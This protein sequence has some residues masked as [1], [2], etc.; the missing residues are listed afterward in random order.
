M[1]QAWLSAFRLRTLP[2]A[3]SSIGMGSFLAAF[4]G[5]FQWSIFALC[6]STTI[7][8]QILSNLANDYGDSIHGADSQERQGPKRMVQSGEISIKAMRNAILVFSLL[9][10]FSGFY[11][12]YLAIDSWQTFWIFLGLGFLCIIAAITYT[13][14]KRP[15]GY[16]GLGD[17]S[18]FIFFGLVAVM[19]T[20]YL[21]THQ[22][23][24]DMVLPAI[25]CGLFATAVLN[26]NNIRDIES[27]KIAG[28]YSLPVR[29][30]RKSAVLY[31]ALLLS[32]GFLSAVGYTL[33]HFSNWM[34]WL[35]VIVFPLLWINFRAVVQKQKASEL[36]PFL[37][38][39]ALTTLLFVLA[40]G[41][42]NLIFI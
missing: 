14:G 35:F 4:Q 40:F 26:V 19:G 1:I 6:A 37:K 34:Q 15:Y 27:D 25:S 18:V 22:L 8:L 24:W 29:M 39:M 36:D 16:L 7:F 20:F 2:L 30:G 28:K 31:H 12:I 23:D 21:H 41:F 5:S 3:L 33:L 38:Q 32:I 42:G 9:S 13:M 11:L 17:I 10:F